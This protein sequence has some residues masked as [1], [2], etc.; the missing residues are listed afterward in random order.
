MGCLLTAGRIF[1]IFINVL[2]FIIGLVL[3]V[4]GM[5]VRFGED[6]ISSYYKPIIAMLESSIKDVYGSDVHLDFKLSDLIGSITLAFILTG[7]FLLIL[8]IFGLGGACCKTKCMLIGFVVMLS[9][10]LAGQIVFIIIFYVKPALVTDKIKDKL[11]SAILSD[12][13]GLN[14]TNVV[15]IGWNF[16]NQKVGCCGVDSYSDFQNAVQWVRAPN[17]ETP[18]SCCMTLPTPPD[19]SCAETGSAADTNNYM[20]KGCFNA[21]WDVV[22][23]NVAITASTLGLGAGLQLLL[24]IVEIALFM[25]VRNNKVGAKQ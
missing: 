22:I 1:C 24:I 10:V 7:V 17:I 12:Y 20:N 4:A 11:K 8:T 9:I 13:Q 6:L 23:G 18:L 3:F 16:V 25:E 19:Y 15:S 5:I 21:L 2:F 14:G